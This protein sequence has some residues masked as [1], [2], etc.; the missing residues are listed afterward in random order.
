MTA[1]ELFTFLTEE[2][3]LDDAT[4]KVVMG[5]AD[6]PK[7]SA[8]ASALVQ[9][10]EYDD[11]E[12][13]AAAL[14]LSYNGTAQR[15]GAKAY[16][17]WYTKNYAVV[18]KLQQDMARYQERY[19]DLDNPGQGGGGSGAGAH[20][21]LSKEDIARMVAEQTD[22]RIGKVYGNQW[23]NIVTGAGKM[24]EKHFRS[25]RKNEIDWDKISAI[26]ATKNNDLVAA[27]DEWDRPEAEKAQAAATE[28]EVNR[29]V[30]EKLNQRQS[31][32]M[33]PAGADASPGSVGI[34]RRPDQKYNRDAVIN[35]A[36]TGKYDATVQ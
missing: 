28:A 24:M 1:K 25:G 11:L 34:G 14:E 36:A 29:R 16:E 23:S 18:Q 6:N 20:T 7:V 31:T 13:R 30:E 5:V 2:A 17:D 3:G 12:R 4:A 21:S 27:Y 22:E 33:F 19:G 8:K 32:Q 10:N 26:A 35:A 15:P 9:K